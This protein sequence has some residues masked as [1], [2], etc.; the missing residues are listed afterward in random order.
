MGGKIHNEDVF[1]EQMG[2]SETWRMTTRNYESGNLIFMKV[3]CPQN[4]N[5]GESQQNLL[6]RLKPLKIL[7]IQ[8]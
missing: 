8:E 7:Y 5:C 2:N 4:G 6:L 3:Q 1:H